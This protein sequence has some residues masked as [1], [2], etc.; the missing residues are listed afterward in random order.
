MIDF[1]VAFVGSMAL[2]YS[3]VLLIEIAVL[4]GVAMH[5]KITK[6]SDH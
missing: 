6:S 5:R 4:L 2:L 3:G 1:L